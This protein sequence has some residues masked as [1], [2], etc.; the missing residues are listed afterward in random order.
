LFAG[1]GRGCLTGRPR[2]RSRFVRRH[3]GAGTGWRGDE[4]VDAVA[5]GDREYRVGVAQRA[6]VQDRHRY[7]ALRPCGLA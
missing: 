1:R 5:R 6:V 7:P 4:H 2:A 3:L